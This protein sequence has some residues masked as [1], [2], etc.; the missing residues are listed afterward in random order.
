MLLSLARKVNTLITV[1]DH[2]LRGGLGSAV[3]E[4]LSDHHSRVSLVRLGIP[5]VHVHHGDPN[6]QH[7]TLGYGPKAIE[8]KL[9]ELALAQELAKASD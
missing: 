2:V 9:E 6:M 5:D 8:K 1:E 7:E 3:A 4:V